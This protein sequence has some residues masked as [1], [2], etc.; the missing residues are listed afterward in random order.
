MGFRD[1]SAFVPET[2]SGAGGALG[3]LLTA[4]GQV[5]NGA[6]RIAAESGVYDPEAFGGAALGLMGRMRALQQQQAAY[7]PSAMRATGPLTNQ[8][9]RAESSG[10]ATATNDHSSALGA[11]QFLRGTWLEMLAKYRPDLTGTPDELAA[12]R[13]DPRLSA[14]MVEAYAGENA[15]RLVRAGHEATPGNVYLTHFAGPS[16]A[17]KILAADPASSA[18]SILGDDAVTA[19]PFLDRMTIG[20]VR[21]WADRKM[22]AQPLAPRPPGPAFPDRADPI[23]GAPAFS[24]GLVAQPQSPSSSGP[25]TSAPLPDAPH[26][27]DDR[28]PGLLTNEPMRLWPVQPP[29]FFPF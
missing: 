2:Y 24:E 3:R 14:E 17:L 23:F 16:G 9:V 10:R 20:D 18:R 22:R 1:G 29:I 21:S 4:T 13:K 28:T 26:G 12:L 6:N 8:I 5:A 19:N 11:G 15:K 25:A 7:R 27:M